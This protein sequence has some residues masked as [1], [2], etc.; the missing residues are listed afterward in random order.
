M[1]KSRRKLKRA[2]KL[3]DQEKTEEALQIVRPILEDDPD[4]A[5]AWWVLAYAVD[6]PIEARR[7]LKRVLEIDPNF[8]HADRARE[9]LAALDAQYPEEAQADELTGF[10]DPF[11]E[12]DFPVEETEPIFPAAESADDLVDDD[13]PDFLGEP[14]ADIPADDP[15]GDL[16]VDPF[17]PEEVEATPAE[18]TL[19]PETP[20]EPADLSFLDEPP[21]EE[22]LATMEE[23]AARKP[24]RGRRRVLTLLTVLVLVCLVVAVV[25]FGL[26]GGA[27]ESSDPGALA[28]VETVPDSV[29]NQMAVAAGQLNN[30]NLGTER[31]VVLANSPLGNTLFVEICDRPGPALPDTILRGMQIMA[32][33]VPPLASELDAVGVSIAVCEGNQRD[34]LYR[35]YVPVAEAQRYLDGDFGDGTKGLSRFQAVWQ[36]P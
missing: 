22:E 33:Q 32:A 2:T 11:A 26:S 8:E 23:Q 13:F 30:A 5:L 14:E 6:D 25:L 3:I 17:F 31:Q 28:A 15:Y 16:D 36:T 7:A 27:D 34:T 18:P 4:N 24:G 1:S 9:M 20:A 35:A 29:L 19:E 10:P 12:D 21:S